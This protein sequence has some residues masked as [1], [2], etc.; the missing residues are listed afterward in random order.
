MALNPPPEGIL[1]PDAL[2]RTA[3]KLRVQ[4]TDACNL[5]CV[6]CMAEDAVF[7]PASELLRPDELGRLCAALRALGATEARIT[8]GEPTVRADFLACVG[9][10]ASAGWERLGLTTNG[11]RM[12]EFSRPLADLGVHGAN[13]SLDS[14]DPDGFRQIARRDGLAKVLEGIDA[15]RS[16]GLAVKINCVAMR[17][18]NESGL[19]AFVEFAARED[20]EVRFLEAMRVGPLAATG[21]DP[22]I[23]AAELRARLGS[24]FGP[25]RPESVA[26]DSTSSVWTFPNGARIG[27][28]ASETEPFCG[29]CSR[30]RLSARGR[31][32]S[33]LFRPE[34]PS[35]RNLS[36]EALVQEVQAELDTKPSGRILSQPED[37]NAI[38]G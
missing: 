32:R 8:G 3:R 29:N 24:L 26:A 37:M 14:L 21:R 16:A 18:L 28:V 13:I 36:G 17:G 12:V 30:L 31:L 34:G 23:P 19:P 20:L 10:V 25:P 6:Y 1:R 22:L 33:C 35:L 7:S 38:G 9:A 4:L 11:L 15:A 2:G 5:R 27:F